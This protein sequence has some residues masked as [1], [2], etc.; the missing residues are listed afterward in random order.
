RGTSDVVPRGELPII[1]AV[2]ERD[3]V[4]SI[5]APDGVALGPLLN[6]Q[7]RR[8]RGR[9][10]RDGPFDDRRPIR[11]R[12]SCRVRAREYGEKNPGQ[13]HCL[14]PLKGTKRTASSH[15]SVNPLG[16]L[17]MRHSA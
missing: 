1:E 15:F 5:A 9:G 3:A 12:A 17:S 13:P 2:V 16:V 6:G 14:P 7:R 11:A 4:K 10:A 8:P